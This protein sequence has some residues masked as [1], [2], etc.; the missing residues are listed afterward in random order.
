MGQSGIRAD[1]LRLLTLV[2][3]CISV[4]GAYLQYTKLI[5]RRVK[6]GSEHNR[7][8][9]SAHQQDIGEKAADDWKEIFQLQHDWTDTMSELAP[10]P[11]EFITQHAPTATVSPPLPRRDSVSSSSTLDNMNH[12]E[13]VDDQPILGPGPL[14]TLLGLQAKKPG[15]VHCIQVTDTTS[16]LKNADQSLMVPSH[17]LLTD[18]GSY[19][20]GF[21]TIYNRLVT[22]TS[23]VWTKRG[24][25]RLVPD[26]T[27][28]NT[29]DVSTKTNN[30]DEL[31]KPENNVH[32]NHAHIMNN[33]SNN[34]NNNTET[35]SKFCLQALGKDVVVSAC[36]I[37]V[38]DQLWDFTRAGG[39]H[40]TFWTIKS[41][42]ALGLCMYSRP[43][44]VGLDDKI[45][46]SHRGVA[47]PKLWPC[48]PQSCFDIWS[49]SPGLFSTNDSATKDEHS[50]NLNAGTNPPPQPAPS[51]STEQSPASSLNF[52]L[53][54]TNKHSS[55][56]SRVLCWIL[57]QPPSHAIKA[58]AVNNT[59]G[60][61]CDLLLF[62]TTA[63]FDGLNTVVVDIG[64][65][66][67]RG[68]IWNKTRS[69]W[70]HVYHHYRDSF[71]WF[72][73][74][75][76]DT[77]VIWPHLTKHILSTVNPDEPRYFG[78]RFN[79]T[80]GEY[81][82]GG[83]GI[84]LSRRA[85]LNVGE[86]AATDYSGTWGKHKFGPEDIYTCNALTRVGVATEDT[87]DSTGAQL[88]LPLGPTAEY[89]KR[90]VNPK[91]WF[92]RISVG[93][94]I[95][96]ACCSKQWVS[97]HYVSPPQQY[98]LDDFVH[99]QCA[100]DQSLWPHVVFNDTQSS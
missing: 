28:G 67:D 62:M 24:Q 31:N 1:V 89:N 13:D 30:A 66:E 54:T 69:A 97:T 2:V 7:H 16:G 96:P 53:P 49:L 70:D 72:F 81:Y 83:S 18:C 10:L 19:D 91:F 15:F 34:R 20:R 9:Q 74:A 42:N 79:A 35:T 77:Y 68:R 93:S 88:F 12:G 61:N 80:R 6:F 92:D 44:L 41:R 33:N 26:E 99:L 65:P 86:A 39:I 46:I 14:S 55:N 52:K 25:I 37:D 5:H 50:N 32:N 100:A 27:N 82:S 47:T 71:D 36:D 17:P 21:D 22:P 75:D 87:V 11:S 40:K 85:L 84:L 60:R 56:G 4:W 98:L 59:W 51:S 48:N 57:T 29:A 73:K 58:V 38:A 95:G 64:G 63:H 23:F 78:R 45:S 76:D 43:P 94:R 8:V 3:L 90:S